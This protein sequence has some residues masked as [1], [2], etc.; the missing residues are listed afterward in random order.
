MVLNVFGRRKYV[1]PKM[2]QGAH[3][4]VQICCSLRQKDCKFKTSPGY[5]ARLDNLVRPCLK[6]KTFFKRTWAIAQWWNAFLA[7][8][9]SRLVPS[10]TEKDLMG[11]NPR[12]YWSAGELCIN[13]S[14]P[15]IPTRRTC[16]S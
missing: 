10:T 13:N 3:L 15:S 4:V 6:M 5:K 16:D 9:R 8:E 7:C 12:R 14:R 1:D 11:N 2:R